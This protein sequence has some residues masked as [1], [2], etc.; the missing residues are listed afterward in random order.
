MGD[1]LSISLLILIAIFGASD[2][3]ELIAH[4][5]SGRARWGWTDASYTRLD[6][7]FYYWLIVL[8]RFLC[9]MVAILLFLVLLDI[10][11]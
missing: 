11:S 2:F 7:P 9:I 8:V 4:L 3:V 5:Q 6:T 10:R 1:T